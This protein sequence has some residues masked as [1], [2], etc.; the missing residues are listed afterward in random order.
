MENVEMWS[1][2]LSRGQ[3]AEPALDLTFSTAP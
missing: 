2:V 1:D 3:I